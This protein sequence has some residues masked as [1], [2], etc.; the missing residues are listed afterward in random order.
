VCE[1]PPDLFVS[2]EDLF[3]GLG[4]NTRCDLDAGI[5]LVD[6]DATEGARAINIVNFCDKVDILKSIS[7]SRVDLHRKLYW[8]TDFAECRPRDCN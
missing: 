1:L 5:M 4:W 3:V 2:G 7:V 8:S 6:K